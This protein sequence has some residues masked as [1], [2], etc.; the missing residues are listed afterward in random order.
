LTIVKELVEAHDGRIEVLSEYEKG[1]T[2]TILVPLND[3]HNS[4]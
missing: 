1:T 3:V 2:F 4:S